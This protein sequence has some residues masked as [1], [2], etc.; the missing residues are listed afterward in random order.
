M[1]NVVEPSGARA[2]VPA[3][4]PS[5][6]DRAVKDTTVPALKE[7]RVGEVSRK[8]RPEHGKRSLALRPSPG[9]M[10][11]PPTRA[12]WPPS[13]AV[14]RGPVAFWLRDGSRGREKGRGAAGHAVLGRE[15]KTLTA[16]RP[17]G[18]ASR[19]RHP[20]GRRA[21]QSTLA[22]G[23]RYFTTGGPFGGTAA[24]PRPQPWD[25][26]SRRRG[27]APTRPAKALPRRQRGSHRE[28]GL[29][30]TVWPPMDDLRAG[31]SVG[32]GLT[33]ECRT[34]ERGRSALPAAWGLCLTSNRHADGSMSGRG[35]RTRKRFALLGGRSSS[36][37]AAKTCVRTP[38]RPAAEPLTLAHG[39]FSLCL[40]GRHWEA[41]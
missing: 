27:D 13:R 7:G 34:V 30:H 2:C 10:Q 37:H 16:A 33:P 22:P 41:R 32:R 23:T 19:T 39:G 15:N 8:R 6:P 18:C 38:H 20:P 9:L 21:P 35:P 36:S 25:W 29:D 3:V 40:S 31:G 5:R 11:H 17:G 12:R 14:H 28:N 26:S 1:S 4:S 24:D